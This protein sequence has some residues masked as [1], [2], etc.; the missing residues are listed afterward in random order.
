MGE[1]PGVEVVADLA[2]EIAVGV[3]LEQL[4]RR[5][6]IGG[7]G[8]VAAMQDEDMALGI[9]RDAGDLAEIEIRRQAQE[10]GNRFIGDR[11]NVF[12]EGEAGDRQPEGASTGGGKKS[13]AIPGAAQRF[14][15]A[16]AVRVPMF[17]GVLPLVAGLKTRR[18]FPAARTTTGASRAMMEGLGAFS[19]A[20]LLP[21]GSESKHDQVSPRRL[22]GA[23]AAMQPARCDQEA[24]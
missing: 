12:G 22:N 13:P 6:A 16:R 19:V 15:A 10:I 23:C 2:Q 21:I 7:P 3:E 9:E 20:R 14:A 18:A 1:G 11:R 8:R 24:A 4:R 17:Q 5:R